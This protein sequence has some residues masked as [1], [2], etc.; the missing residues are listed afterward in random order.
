MSEEEEWRAIPGLENYEA[1]SLGRIR[2]LD[3]YREFVGRWNVLQR[4]FYPGRILA[5]RLKANGWG[6]FY[7][8]IYT[9][10]GRYVQVNR[11]VCAAF[12]GPAPSARHEAA[13]LNSDS[14]INR[15][16]NLSWATPKENCA[17]KVLHGTNPQGERNGCARLRDADIDPLFDRYISGDKA[18]DLGAELGVS[19][20]AVKAVV[21]RRT[22][23]H[24]PISESKVQAAKARAQANIIATRQAANAERS[25]L[26]RHLPKPEGT[27]SIREEQSAP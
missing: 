27:G 12:H 9:D 16:D 2:S 7:A 18:A 21:A 22:W 1:S 6:G 4:R 26:A 24:V 11:C 14:L 23:L 5:E 17:H 13:H 19:A 20:G 10:G 25:R 15:E 3:R 8:S